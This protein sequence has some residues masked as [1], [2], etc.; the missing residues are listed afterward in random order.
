MNGVLQ[1]GQ[2]TGTN[3]TLSVIDFSMCVLQVG[4]V[5][6]ADNNSSSK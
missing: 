1:L 3:S 2:F 6:F 4:Q 5:P